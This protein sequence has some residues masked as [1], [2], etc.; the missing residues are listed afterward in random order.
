[1]LMC[2][3]SLGVCPAPLLPRRPAG[4][5]YP[6]A[7]P[8]EGKSTT[9]SIRVSSSAIRH[10]T[11]IAMPLRLAAFAMLLTAC[12]CAHAQQG[13]LRDHGIDIGVLPPGRLNAITDVPGVAVGHSTLVNGNNVRTG[14]TAIL[15]HGGNIFRDNVP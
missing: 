8:G 6:H 12:M 9:P 7:E 5:L 4:W 15:P 3:S 1:E 14:V 10:D 11:D 2:C 13:S